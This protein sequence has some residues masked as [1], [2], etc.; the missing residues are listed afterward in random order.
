[1]FTSGCFSYIEN[2][3]KNRFP[4]TPNLQVASGE[5]YFDGWTKSSH[6]IG[7]RYLCN[8]KIATTSDSIVGAVPYEQ[9]L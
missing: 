3:E 7:S 9:T 1:M 4:A 6:P 2:V 8:K 5:Q